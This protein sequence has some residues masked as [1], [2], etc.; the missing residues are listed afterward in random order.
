MTAA[1]LVSGACVDG[2]PSRFARGA[3]VLSLLLG[4]TL[5]A[6]SPALGD[7]AGYVAVLSGACAATAFAGAYVLWVRAGLVAHAVAGISALSAA[8]IE[9]LHVTVGLPGAL[10]VER[11]S[12]LESGTVVGL[13]GLV[14]VVLGADLRK[15]RPHRA[16]EHPYAL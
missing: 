16:P 4:L 1:G 14:L 13:A 12:V 10:R 9:G 6:I 7:A 3:A 11:L 15:R 2:G 8:V 5:L